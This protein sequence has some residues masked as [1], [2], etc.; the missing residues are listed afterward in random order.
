MG[1]ADFLFLQ[2]ITGLTGGNLSRHLAKLEEA[3]LIEIEKGYA[4]RRPITTAY[5]TPTGASAI[6]EHWLKLD[7]LRT[8]GFALDAD[9]RDPR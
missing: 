9:G 2:R 6:R 8:A 3:G 4:G 7:Q 1:H 5:L